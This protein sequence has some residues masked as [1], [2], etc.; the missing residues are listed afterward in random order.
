[1]HAITAPALAQPVTSPPLASAQPAAAPPLPSEAFKAYRAID[2]AIRVWSIP[3]V[4]DTSTFPVVGGACVVLRYQGEVLGRGTALGDGRETIVAAARAAFDE[5]S[6]RMPVENDAL[7]DESIRHL[8]GEVTISLEL[9]G[10]L[11][12]MDARTYEEAAA[13]LSPGLDGVATRIGARVAGVFPSTI[14]TQSVAAR[15][16]FASAAS[17]AGDNPSLG[18]T[19]MD[20][21]IDQQGAKFYRFRV[22]HIA[23]ASPGAAP[24]VLVR[25][26]R[27]V[28]LTDVG[29]VA[30]SETADRIAEHL[31]TR[32]WPG[33][34]S[35]GMVGTYDP[36]RDTFEP[37][38]ASPVEQ[39]T[40]ALAL[41]RYAR[42]LEAGSPR[43]AELMAYVDRIRADLVKVEA[44]EEAAGTDPVAAAAW[45]VLD[46]DRARLLAPIP[47]SDAGGGST[48]P[49]ADADTASFAEQCR[50]TVH[51]S[52]NMATG[53]DPKVAPPAQAMVALALVRMAAAEKGATLREE[54]VML[55]DAACRGVFRN[56][57]PGDLVSRMPWLGWAE[58]ELADLHADR[59]IG[60]RTA[61]REMRTLVWEHQ[62]SPVS[63][64]ASDQ[65]GGGGDMVGGIVFSAGARPGAPTPLPTW[66]SAR[67]IAFLASMLADER[68]TPRADRPLELARL[69]G[70]LRFLRQLQVDDATLW[71]CQN[72]RRALG[73]IRSAAWDQHLASDASAMTLLAL[74]EAMRALDAMAAP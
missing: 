44:G 56:A 68:L 34:E 41:L 31:L 53:Y 8:A 69:V 5:A 43:R 40:A 66:Q 45:I 71:M 39:L 61:L 72:S 19:E 3:A 7:R 74:V 27:A 23:Q 30:L 58:V 46:S 11:I 36:G 47:A 48:V 70:A 2:D 25:G 59:Q 10:A 38:V 60:A 18:L 67:P 55:A 57:T 9:A 29:R 54:A 24:M 15:Q 42:A 62:V 35:Y 6:R 20:K 37:K 28:A 51:A 16:A 73:G 63:P 13:R 1:V 12:P 50:R 22:V 64:A 21:L 33:Q 49:G 52:F 4:M 14:L 32:R 65:Q 17:Q 26:Q